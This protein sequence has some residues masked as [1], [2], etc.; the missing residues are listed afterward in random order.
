[1]GRRHRHC[2]SGRRLI[3]GVF[4]TF[5]YL[6]ITQPALAESN[7]VLE[8]N[9]VLLQTVRNTRFAPMLTARALAI[10][11]TCMYDAWAAYDP[12]AVG[13]Q[14]GGS[15]RRPDTDHTDANKQ[16][17]ISFAAYRALVDLFP[18]QKTVL[19]DPLMV[20][21]GYNP[22]DTSTDT[23]TPAGI[24][25]VA[26]AAVLVFRHADGSNQLG[27]LHPGAYSDYAATRR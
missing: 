9:D 17:A 14:F 23:T 5:I 4:L 3:G 12:V 19:L 26:A 2:L 25:N 15:L 27:D 22:L 21:L 20:S 6:S 18:T 13:T 7:V 10:V 11:H 16:H 1:M 8:W 24:G